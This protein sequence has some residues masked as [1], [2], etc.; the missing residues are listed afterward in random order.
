V[1]DNGPFLLAT[2]EA[3]RFRSILAGARSAQG[4]PVTAPVPPAAAGTPTANCSACGAPFNCGRDDA[5]GCWCA[6]LP[7]LD[8]GRYDAAAGCLCEPCL[9]AALDATSASSSGAEP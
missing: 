4:G 5:A 9:R 3:A 8:R 6:R 7:P 2:G 1:P